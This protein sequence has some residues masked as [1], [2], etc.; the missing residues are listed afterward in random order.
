[1][2]GET[3]MKLLAVETAT[4][5][6]S[7]A[8]LDGTT[9]LCQSDEEAGLSHAKWLV[10]TI[11]RLLQ[12]TG[13]TLSDLDGFAVSIGPGSFTGLRVGLATVTGFRMVTGLPLVTVPTME[14][15]AWNLR[16]EDRQL[17]PVLKART[18]EVYWAFYRWEHAA[19]PT[20]LTE[21]RVGSLESLTQSIKGPT[22]VLGEGWVIYKDELR[23]LMR[24]RSFEVNEAPPDALAASAVSVG[25]AAL[26][27]L[28]RG[29]VA[30]RG[31]VPLYVQRTE[32]EVTGPRPVC[33]SPSV[34]E[35]G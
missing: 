7:V 9:V 16:A 24:D 18:G 11:D 6:Q 4:R 28:A 15:L 19:R 34:K 1:M 29:E 35:D 14:A 21:E 30:G 22:V 23:R 33:V 8:V 2:G 26:E 25:L 5:R 31:I 13:L 20:R 3:V 17:C 27:R 10:P 32:A 12:S